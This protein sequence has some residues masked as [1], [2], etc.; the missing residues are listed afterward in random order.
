[1]SA[2]SEP[3]DLH[4]VTVVE[5]DVMDRLAVDAGP[6]AAAAVAEEEAL[7]G[8]HHDGVD[9]GD[10]GGTEGKVAAASLAD[11]DQ[12]AVQG[13]VGP[14][15]RSVGDDQG[16]LGGIES[17]NDFAIH[18]TSSNPLRQRRELIATGREEL[19]AAP[20]ANGQGNAGTAE[21][22]DGLKKL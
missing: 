18:G 9:F 8:A 12:I 7:R 19:R 2:E 3:A 6:G 13:A 14:L 20:W 1:M 10:L 22:N 15:R 16:G 5:A 11:E 21:R 4:D 17:L